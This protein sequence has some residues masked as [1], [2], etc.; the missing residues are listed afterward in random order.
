MYSIDSE[1]IIY[2]VFSGEP[3]L[4]KSVQYKNTKYWYN[5]LTNDKGRR[6]FL[7]HRLVAQA[8]IPNPDN[9]SQVNHKDGNKSNNTVANL[10][11]VS[12]S[13]NHKHAYRVLG[14]APNKTSLGKT[15]GAHA[16][17]KVVLQYSINMELI[18]EFASTVEAA[19][20]LGVS[21]KTISKCALGNLKTYK[22]FIWVYK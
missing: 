12:C 21:A 10:E 6:K 11:W 19:E 1:G 16:K 13:D 2:S 3:K 8:F 20:A 17:A 5:E 18:Q 15:G 7:V 9:L 4:K 22:G 14:K